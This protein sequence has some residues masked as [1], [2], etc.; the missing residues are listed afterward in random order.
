MLEQYG[1]RPTLW[2]KFL[3]GKTAAESRPPGEVFWPFGI[4]RAVP[5][6]VDRDFVRTEIGSGRVRIVADFGG[7]SHHTIFLRRGRYTLNAA[8]YAYE[9]LMMCAMFWRWKELSISP[10]KPSGDYNLPPTNR[11]GAVI[12]DRT[13]NEDG[14]QTVLFASGLARNLVDFHEL[15]DFN[16]ALGLG[17]QH[18]FTPWKGGMKGFLGGMAHCTCYPIGWPRV[19]EKK[20]AASATGRPQN[21]THGSAKWASGASAK[22]WLRNVR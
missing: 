21:T 20:F 2:E 11:Y 9:A 22:G 14:S 5:N 10:R 6:F 19:L 7:K 13:D 17:Y 16:R 12:L 15:A 1:F 18:A 4:E 3:G 8:T